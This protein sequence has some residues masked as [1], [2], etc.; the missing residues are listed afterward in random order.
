MRPFPA[1]SNLES[2][3][4]PAYE[5][6]HESDFA[7]IAKA[8]RLQDYLFRFELDKKK[9]KISREQRVVR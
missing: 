1:Q 3:R 2:S 6:G 8:R 4:Q 7:L 5:L 9:G